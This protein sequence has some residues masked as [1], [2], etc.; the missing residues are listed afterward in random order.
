MS[1]E[2]D[3]DW[4]DFSEQAIK[5]EVFPGQVSGDQMLPSGRFQ[6][7]SRRDPMGVLPTTHQ[8]PISENQHQKCVRLLYTRGHIEFD[9]LSCEQQFIAYFME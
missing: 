3:M 1:G 5:F 2:A 8:I 4:Q 9:Q 6:L 7:S